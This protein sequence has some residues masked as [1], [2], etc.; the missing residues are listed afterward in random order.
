[1][2]SRV[3]LQERGEV[4]ELEGFAGL[5]HIMDWMVNNFNRTKLW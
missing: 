1:M 4:S 2:M 5:L 3:R